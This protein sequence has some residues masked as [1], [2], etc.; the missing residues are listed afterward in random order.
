MPFAGTKLCTF[1]PKLLFR[2]DKGYLLHE[3]TVNKDLT[4][5]GM[6]NTDLLLDLAD[7]LVVEGDDYGIEWEGTLHSINKLKY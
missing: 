3:V 7:R 2:D 6:F 1:D 5:Y 4:C